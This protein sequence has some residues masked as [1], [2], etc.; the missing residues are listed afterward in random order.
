MSSS[1]SLL[2]FVVVVVLLLLLLVV[3][4]VV[5]HAAAAAAVVSCCCCCSRSKRVPLEFICHIYSVCFF[6]LHFVLI[7]TKALFFHYSWR[8][9]HIYRCYCETEN[10]LKDIKL[11]CGHEILIFNMHRNG[12]ATNVC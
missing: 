11:H 3:V 4:V 5:V 6:F 7:H 9:T 1:W 10:V 12:A 8:N 2:L